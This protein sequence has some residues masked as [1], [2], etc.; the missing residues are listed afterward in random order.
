MLYKG[1]IAKISLQDNKIFSLPPGL[2]EGN[3]Q[4]PLLFVDSANPLPWSFQEP[5]C[6]IQ[7]SMN[8]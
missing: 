5:C 1:P 8:Y 3:T 7:M 2:K 4:S 6:L